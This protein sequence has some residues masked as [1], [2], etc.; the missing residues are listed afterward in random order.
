MKNNVMACAVVGP[1]T[2][3]NADIRGAN[4]K[5]W[6]LYAGSMKIVHVRRGGLGKFSK[7]RAISTRYPSADNK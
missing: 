2:R 6:I 4:K 1:L 5:V 3:A 7:F